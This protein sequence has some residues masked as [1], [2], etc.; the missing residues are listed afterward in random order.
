MWAFKE[1]YVVLQ[2]PLE[3]ECLFL[4]IPGKWKP[5]MVVLCV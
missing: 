3:A 5:I 1:Q 2:I 4:G